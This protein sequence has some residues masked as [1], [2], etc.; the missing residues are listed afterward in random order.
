[1]TSFISKIHQSPRALRPLSQCF[2]W[3]D[4][5]LQRMVRNAGYTKKNAILNLHLKN[6]RKWQLLIKARSQDFFLFP[7]RNWETEMTHSLIRVFCGWEVFENYAFKS[8]KKE[9]K[10]H[11][12]LLL[13]QS[14]KDSDKRAF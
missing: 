8:K 14:P 10:G 12:V 4:F 6:V 1:M 9:V 5:H 11:A 3:F 13:T 7:G 2:S